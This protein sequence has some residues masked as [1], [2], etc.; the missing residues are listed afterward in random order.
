MESFVSVP[1]AGGVNLKFSFAETL[2][3][4]ALICTVLV[5]VG[6]TLWAKF[7]KTIETRRRLARTG[8]FV[9][10]IL[11]FFYGLLFFVSLISAEFAL[12][13]LLAVFTMCHLVG[14]KAASS[15]N[16]SLFSK[17]KRRKVF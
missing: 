7:G 6:G 16:G 13:V 12:S 11:C 9:H 10:K 5:V 8:G 2:S 17:L 4:V 15:G 14:S 1:L 3:I